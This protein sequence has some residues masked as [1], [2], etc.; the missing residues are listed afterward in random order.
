MQQNGLLSQPAWNNESL[1]RFGG[2]T[3]NLLAACAR[4]A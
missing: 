4:T 3:P 1:N 2:V